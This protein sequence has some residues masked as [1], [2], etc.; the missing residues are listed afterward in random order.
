M[1][2]IHVEQLIPGLKV[3]RPVYDTNG[4]MLLNYNVE[5]KSEYISYLKRLGISSIYVEDPLLHDVWVE[6]VLRDETRQQANILVKNI[7]DNSKIISEKTLPGLLISKTKEINQ[8]LDDIVEQ[9]LHNPHLVVNLTDIRTTDSYTFAH[10]VNVATLSII[11]GISMGLPP[12][13]LKKIGMGALLHDLGKTKIPLAILNKKGRL[14][15][16]EFEEIKNHPQYGYNMVNLSQAVESPSAKVIYQHHERINGEGYPNR[17]AESKIHPYAKICSIADVY[18]ALTADRP[19]RPGFTPEK[20]LEHL[21][22]CGHEFDQEI[23]QHL[24]MHV[25]AYPIGT[26]VGLSNGMAGVVV[27]N[28]PGYPRNPKVRVLCYKENFKPVSPYEIDL[29]EIIDVII[30]ET[31]PHTE[32]PTNFQSI[33]KL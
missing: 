21:E 11:T 2:K 9:L 27:H 31:Y 25:A 17:L 13:Q 3:A 26:R 22:G 14:T 24:F 29:T 5:I 23:L 32:F 20:A 15:P 10:S 19:Y 33:F 30:D 1:R 8:V 7:L 16:D 18:D 4:F 28:T 12:G 6:D